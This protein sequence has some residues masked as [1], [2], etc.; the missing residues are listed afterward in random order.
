MMFTI[1]ALV[2]LC[3]FAWMTMRAN[4]KDPRGD[5]RSVELH[6]LHARQDMRLACYLLGGILIMLGIIADKLH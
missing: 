1:G 4:N 3:V 6:A 2:G 5:E